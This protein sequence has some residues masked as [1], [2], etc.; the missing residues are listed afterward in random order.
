MKYKLCISGGPNQVFDG[1][2][3]DV[4]AAFEI[5]GF[6]YAGAETNPRLRPELHGHPKFEGLHGP[7]WDGDGVRYEDQETYK[8]LSR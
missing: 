3:A 4:I 8:A 2:T 6:K 1:G 5:R 7:M